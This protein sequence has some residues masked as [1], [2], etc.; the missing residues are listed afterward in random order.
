MVDSP[1]LLSLETIADRLHYAGSDRERRVRRLF[2]R[3]DVPIIKLGRGS[4]FVT[5]FQFAALIE[6]TTCLPCASA[7]KTG[8]SVVRSVSGGKRASSKSILAAQIDATLQTPTDRSSKPKRA[9]KSFD[10]RLCFNN[11]QG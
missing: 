5:E 7:A 11:I 10:D 6:A 1:P 2:A 8:T 3:H 9:T 4:Y